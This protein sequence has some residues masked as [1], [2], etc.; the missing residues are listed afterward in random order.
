ME[1]VLDIQQYWDSM[2][3]QHNA[4]MHYVAKML[5]QIKPALAKVEEWIKDLERVIDCSTATPS[6]LR[7]KVYYEN[8][9]LIFSPGVKLEADSLHF[10]FDIQTFQNNN[11]RFISEFSLIPE[12]YEVQDGLKLNILLSLYIKINEDERKILSFNL[13]L[14]DEISKKHFLQEMIKSFNIKKSYE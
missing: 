13:D 12:L 2:L 3:L 5:G 4:N 9:E 11:E 7:E 8:I 1:T 6:C 10:S 14:F